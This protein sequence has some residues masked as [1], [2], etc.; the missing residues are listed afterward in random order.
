[1]TPIIF[2]NSFLTLKLENFVSIANLPMYNKQ[3]SQT[4]IKK[5]QGNV[6][7]NSQVQFLNLPIEDIKPLVIK[8]LKDNIP[9]YLGIYHKKF[10][11][12]KSG[13]LDTRLYNYKE[14][15][16][17]VPLTKKEALDTYDIWFDH[18]MTICGVHLVDNKPIRWKVEDSEG[19]KEKVNGHYVM[20]DNYF[21]EFVLKVIIDKKYLSQE[22]LILLEQEPIKVEVDNPV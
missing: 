6:H 11:D 2:K 21:N 3:Y 17:F 16:N 5:Y 7:Q 14:I 13:V 19:D 9:V 12:K 8:Q 1:M 20:N 4:Y 18:A 22:Q 10:R 15:L